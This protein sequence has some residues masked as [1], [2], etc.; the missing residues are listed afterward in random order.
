MTLRGFYANNGDTE[1]YR[2]FPY[3]APGALFGKW[4]FSELNFVS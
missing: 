2:D 4:I 3:R 1:Y